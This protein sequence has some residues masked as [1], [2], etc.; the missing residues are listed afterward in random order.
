MKTKERSRAIERAGRLVSDLAVES[1]RTRDLV[2]HLVAIASLA[3]VL[4]E[5]EEAVRDH[6]KIEGV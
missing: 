1:P 4:S 3:G 2:G 5:L 6:R